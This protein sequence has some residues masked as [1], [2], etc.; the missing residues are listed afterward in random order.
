MPV[1]SFKFKKLL[2]RSCI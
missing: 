2:C 1:V